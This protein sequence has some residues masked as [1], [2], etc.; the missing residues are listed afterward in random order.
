M[1]VLCCFGVLACGVL[2]A[3]MSLLGLKAGDSHTSHSI[4]FNS[5]LARA[6]CSQTAGLEQAARTRSSEPVTW[7]LCKLGVELLM[8]GLVLHYAALLMH[9]VVLDTD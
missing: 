3:C 8:H 7:V 4:Q 6:R 9:G 1:Q 2:W 5:H